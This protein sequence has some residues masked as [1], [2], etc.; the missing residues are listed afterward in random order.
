M[1]DS[2]SSLNMYYEIEISSVTQFF[3]HFVLMN[4]LNLLNMIFGY[5]DFF[6]EPKVALT[7]DLEYYITVL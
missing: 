1:S 3:L 7:K 5:H 4:L 6:P 2:N